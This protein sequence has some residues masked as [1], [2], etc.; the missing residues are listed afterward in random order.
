MFFTIDDLREAYKAG[1]KKRNEAPGLKQ[2]AKRSGSN[3][4]MA[5]IGAPSRYLDQE[6]VPDTKTYAHSIWTNSEFK[7]SL[8]TPTRPMVEIIAEA[9]RDQET[10]ESLAKGIKCDLIP[11]RHFLPLAEAV[12]AAIERERARK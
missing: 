5:A 11:A 2:R 4:L 9:I 10:S 12:M 3:G 8:P 6:L 7:K 1:W